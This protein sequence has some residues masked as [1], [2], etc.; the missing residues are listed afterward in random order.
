MVVFTLRVTE[1]PLDAMVDVGKSV[2]I[3]GELPFSKKSAVPDP[4]PSAGVE[5]V[6]PVTLPSFPAQFASLHNLPS[7][8]ESINPASS[9]SLHPSPSESISSLLGI[10]SPSVSR[11]FPPSS[12]SKIPSLSSSKSTL[13]FIPSLSGSEDTVSWAGLEYAAPGEHTYALGVAFSL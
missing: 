12:T 11:S 13:F 3:V 1:E 10:P 7:P 2:V 9:T 4:S 5:Y 8:S 6:C